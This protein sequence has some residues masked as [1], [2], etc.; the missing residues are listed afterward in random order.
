MSG[1]GWSATH[2]PRYHPSLVLPSIILM[3]IRSLLIRPILLG[4]LLLAAP[5]HASGINLSWDD[6]GRSGAR[7]KEFACAT[8]AGLPHVLVASVVPPAGLSR[9][10]GAEAMLD[11]QFE[12][13]S[14]PAWW[15]LGQG[16]R[17]GKLTSSFDFTTGPYSCEDFFRGNG[18]G[19]MQLN[20]Q[21]SRRNRATIKVGVGVAPEREGSLNAG[22][23][24]YLFKL[25]ILN[26]GTGACGDCKRPACIQLTSVLLVQPALVGNYLVT[27]RQDMNV[28]MW[29][30]GIS[31]PDSDLNE[32]RADAVKNQTWGQI[33][34]LYR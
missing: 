29:Q 28:A 12:G 9:F 24:Y 20:E 31:S 14:Y 32:C 30:G 1:V 18:Y 22:R 17:A 21:R 34:N 23:E 5:A 27:D 15:E 25:V 7:N 13:E 11:I 4:T 16:C 26:G 10:I 6:C 3:R 19:G 33:K 8:D 2:A